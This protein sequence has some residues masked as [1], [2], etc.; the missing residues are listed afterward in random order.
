VFQVQNPFKQSCFF[1]IS[2]ALMLAFRDP[3]I[4]INARLYRGT[5][6]D[7]T[8]IKRK[9]FGLL[10]RSVIVLHDNARPH[11]KDMLPS[12]RWKV[13]DHP[14]YSP[15]LSPCDYQVLFSVKKVL[16]SRIFWLDKELKAAVVQWF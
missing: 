16:N 7:R 6:R 10:T 15:D 13:L 2:G 8:I 5:L 12:I 3:D 1:D 11:V 14:P 9:R 4:T